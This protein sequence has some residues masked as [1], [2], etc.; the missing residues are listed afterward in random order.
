MFSQASLRLISLSSC[1]ATGLLTA[2][3]AP[4]SLTEYRKYLADP[5]HG[6][7]QTREVDGVTIT[8][9]YH[10]AELLALQDFTVG[11]P[12]SAAPGA[13]NSLRQAYAGKTHCTLDL[14]RSGQEI[15]NRFIGDRAAYQ[16]VLNYLNTGLAADVTLST[17]ARDSVTAASSFYLR[18]YSTTGRS[19]VLLVF[20]TPRRAA[21][22]GFSLTLYGNKLG[23]GTQR[24]VFT[25]ADVAA[26]PALQFP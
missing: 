21:D 24:F 9:T 26:L 12:D 19:T 7:A 5:A 1:L 15:E 13:F 17:T 6:L 2:C 10:P 20:P 22:Q 3:T 25:G 18:H 11:L 23:L 14:S 4:V 16:Q 8:C